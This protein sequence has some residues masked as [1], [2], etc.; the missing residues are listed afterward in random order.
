MKANNLP[1]S[2]AAVTTGAKAKN[3]GSDE[4]VG[5]SPAKAAKKGDDN[6][7]NGSQSNAGPDFGDFVNYPQGNGQ[8]H[9][10][11]GQ[12][13]GYGHNHHAHD[14][15]PV[16]GKPTVS[17]S[18]ITVAED[19]F[20]LVT[21]TLSQISRSTVKVHYATADGT[22]QAGLDY[23]A[24]YGDAVFEPGQTTVTVRVPILGDSLDEAHESFVLNL[25]NGKGVDIAVGT[26]TI[27]IQD[28]DAPSVPGPLT[29]TTDEDALPLS[30]D[31][32]S[33]VS[34][35]NGDP[36][37]TESLGALVRPDGREVTYAVVDSTLVLD[38]RQFNDLSQGESEQVVLSYQVT[39]GSGSA[40]R[41]LTITVLGAN[42]DPLAADVS[43]SI[44]E[45]GPAK[46]S[47]AFAGRDPDAH[48]A[49]SYQVLSQ[50]EAG[51]VTVN[52]D[53]TFSFDPAGQFEALRDG[54]EQLVSF[55]Y[56]VTDEFGASSQA[57]ASIR[58]LGVNDAPDAQDDTT[59]TLR[60]ATRTILTADLL[61]NDHDVERD[62]LSL[63]SVANGMGGNVALDAEGNVVF[64]PELG[65]V[66]DASFTYTIADGHGGFDTATVTVKVLTTFGNSAPIA[67]DDFLL[68][69]CGDDLLEGRPTLIGGGGNDTLIGGPGNDTMIVN[70]GDTVYGG[71]GNDTVVAVGNTP[72]VID[73]GA[74]SVETVIGGNGADTITTGPGID[75]V[76][77]GG[78]DDVIVIGGTGTATVSGGD[79]RD[80]VVLTGEAAEYDYHWTGSGWTFTAPNGSSTTVTGVE[81]ANF[82]D[83]NVEFD[84]A[85]RPCAFRVYEDVAVTIPKGLLL[86]NDMDADG[87][88]LSIA[89]VQD[90]NNANVH[91]DGNGNVWFLGAPDYNGLATFTYTITDGHGGFSTPT[92]TVKVW[93][94]N[95]LP[96]VTGETLNTDEDVPV[97]IAVADL[98]ANDT[99]VEGDTLSVSSVGNAVGGSVALVDGIVTFSP[100]ANFNGTASFDYVVSDNHGG[101]RT[102]T[103]TVHVA[104]VNDAPMAGSATLTVSEDGPSA[105]F[106]LPVSDVDGG[107]V[108]T[109]TVLSQPEA[110][111]LV[112]N[113]DGSVTFDPAGQFE[114][115][116]E[117]ESRDLTFDYRVTDEFGASSDSTITIHVKGVN[118]APVAVADHVMTVA[119]ASRTIPLTTLLANDTDVE[120]DQLSLVSVEGAVGGTVSRDSDGQVVF[121]PDAGFHGTG[122]FTYT[123]SD[124]HG[125]FSTATVNVEVLPKDNSGPT[126]NA[127]FLLGG[128][129]DDELVAVPSGSTLAGGTGNDTLTG[130]AGNDTLIIDSGDVI[131]GGG[132]NDT[133]VIVDDGGVTVDMGA[134]GTET[135]IGGVGG[136]TVTIGS[137]GGTVLTGGGG[138]TITTGTGN[139]TVSAGGG[140]DVIV[141]VPG[142]SDTISG[143]AGT[144]TVVIPGDAGDYDYIRTDNGWVISGPGGSSTTITGVEVIDFDGLE[145]EFDEAMWPKGFRVLEDAT[146]TI[147]AKLLLGN[148]TDPDGDTLTIVSVQDANNASVEMTAKGN[149]RFQGA[150]DYN[151]LA[152]FTY[153]ITDGHG[154]FSTAT[155]TVKVWPVND[156]SVL[157]SD[158]VSTLEDTAV[159][160]AAADLLAND[161]DVD[162][163]V[164]NVTGVGNAQGGSVS[165]VNGQITFTP[166]ANFNG[167]AR[168]DYTVSDG[169]GG[170]AT[171]T[172]TVDVGA[173]ND[174]PV[175]VDDYFSAANAK[176]ITISAAT[177]L[178]NDRDPEGAP[179]QLVSVANAQG[180]TVSYNAATGA[181]VFTSVTGESA[182]TFDYTVVD[183]H[184]LSSTATV[185]VQDFMGRARSSLVQSAEMVVN[186][187]TTYDQSG[188][189]VA[190]LAN[191][192]HVVAWQSYGQ[193]GASWGVYGRVTSRE[194]V[195]GDE[196]KINTHTGDH[197]LDP[198]VSALAGGGFV[199]TWQ[200]NNQD[201]SGYGVYGQ[202]Y[203]AAG[204]PEGDEFRINNAPAGEQ[205]RARMTGLEDGGF[206]VTWQSGSTMMGRRY[207]AEGI[208]TANEYP[209]LPSGALNSAVA[210]LSGGGYV[211]TW[212]AW[213][214][215]AEYG[216]YRVYAKTYSSTGQVGP[217]LVVN[218][219]GSS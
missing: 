30:I 85:M 68:G 40:P 176:D 13:N 160:I 17:V 51:I 8:G 19:G 16:G 120:G 159:L 76:Y 109:T 174:A 70:G 135:V 102:A 206:L 178:A 1:K 164:L 175:A 140:D 212:K 144:D 105:P 35:R 86:V 196:I 101:Y 36:V 37:W 96:V 115:L 22:A 44:S 87:D 20:A 198:Q 210:G 80:T 124:G 97:T 119:G 27:T 67:F 41:T 58:V 187:T 171:Q 128:W 217:D 203:D 59:V 191:G 129:G 33:G 18:S 152:T 139:D 138:D 133:V 181:I 28:D 216:V 163:D 215:S 60:N 150:P 69:T 107:A 14:C 170:V 29:A 207:D 62:T 190:V 57:I 10:Q 157:V 90:A 177:L 106:S 209:L 218:S 199:V 183:D 142:G 110:G 194:G 141:V 88:T 66:G 214:G 166:L 180:G 179:L 167:P 137:G 98:L 188:P 38:P 26:G 161:H 64:T 147:P 94:V 204:L 61:A 39:D 108:L 9:E 169:H 12:G 130:G 77:G 24:V 4:N 192:G 11:H 173:V 131:S 3:P 193:D 201:G 195:N 197:Q 93:P 165:L 205:T 168:F 52:A 117:G 75:A 46:T 55:A 7:G 82:G 189:V 49:L 156:A 50:P 73:M 127:D 54:D 5:Q 118:D 79:G 112:D 42:D 219:G 185:H 153:T 104:S 136:D 78:G 48:A 31:L 146:V 65:F 74:T 186:T 158:S 32:L 71:G 125:G 99:D 84:A 15:P 63:V 47:L 92:V 91:L 23:Q 103:A 89:S 208:A 95:D 182:G 121:T 202:R 184:G 213:Y 56:Q 126:A 154:D 21:L 116:G 148:D 6:P 81:E 162:G 2:V 132:G 123:I 111:I 122:H 114:T 145:V 43:Y 53:G 172:V 113:G 211:V 134:T 151:G 200:S 25:S 155:V 100:T 45:D 149:V 34:D 72:L 143:G 83:L